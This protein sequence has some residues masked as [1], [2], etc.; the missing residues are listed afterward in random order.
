MNLADNIHNINNQL[1]PA[2][3]EFKR[4]IKFQSD[5]PCGT[6]GALSRTNR[7]LVTLNLSALIRVFDLKKSDD[8]RTGGQ[9]R[10]YGDW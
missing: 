2:L 9:D 5:G 6:D 4:T 10:K 3:E 1:K 8:S 7:K